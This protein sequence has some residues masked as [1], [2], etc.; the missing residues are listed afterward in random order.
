[1]NLLH[2]DFIEVYFNCLGNL[3]SDITPLLAQ[4]IENV[5]VL[6]D[7]EAAW[8]NFVESGQVWALIIGVFIGYVFKGFTSY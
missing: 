7:M 5:D 3:P 2:Y 4:T 8:T 6:G 1:M